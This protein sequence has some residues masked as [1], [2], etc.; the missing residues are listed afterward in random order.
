[1]NWKDIM[2]E[3]IS[4]TSPLLYLYRVGV[5]EWLPQLFREIWKI[6]V[7]PFCWTIYWRGAPLKRPA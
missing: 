5:I 6:P 1:M 3:V 7:V 2:P 4:N